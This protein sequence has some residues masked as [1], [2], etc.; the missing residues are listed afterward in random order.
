[1]VLEEAK[2]H[3]SLPGCRSLDALR[4]EATDRGCMGTGMQYSTRGPQQC[5]GT[6]T[7][8]YARLQY[9]RKRLS[10]SLGSTWRLGTRLPVL[11]LAGSLV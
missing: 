1:M 5:A 9:I 2:Q 7:L 4:A 11:L 8:L 3:Q 6:N 10:W